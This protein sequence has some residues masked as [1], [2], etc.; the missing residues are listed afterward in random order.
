MGS[1]FIPPQRVESFSMT[2]NYCTEAAKLRGR[3]F[4]TGGEFHAKAL[5]IVFAMLVI[6]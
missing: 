2:C 5:R 6:A 3:I 4:G 1:D